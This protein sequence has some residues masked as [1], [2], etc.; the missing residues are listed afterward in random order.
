MEHSIDLAACHFIQDVSPLSTQ[1]IVKKLK[2][3]LMDVAIDDAVNFD[4]LDACLTAG[5]FD[6]YEGSEGEGD[7]DEEILNNFDIAVSVGKALAL[8]KQVSPQTL[9]RQ[10]Q[11]AQ[12]LIK[13][14]LKICASPQACA[15]FVKSCESV[16]IPYLQLMLWVRMHWAS[17]YAFLDCTLVLKKV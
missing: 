3:A 10:M 13:F 7:G 9:E 2:H 1:K 15:F 12:I 5:G 8:V 6:S 4:V 14:T 16:D 11:S 17:L